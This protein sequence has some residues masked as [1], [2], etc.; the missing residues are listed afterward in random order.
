MK[1]PTEELERWIEQEKRAEPNPFTSTRI[2][3]SIENELGNRRTESS[4]VF[5]RLLQPVS[6]TIALVV[7]ILIG[8]Y[9]ARYSP[10]TQVADPISLEEI[11][12]ELFISEIMAEDHILQLST[13]EP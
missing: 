12:N 1:D 13:P 8:A 5:L 6:L 2:L 7:G 4:P 10:D 11:R 9:T 3:Q